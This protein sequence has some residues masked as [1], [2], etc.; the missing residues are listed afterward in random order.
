MRT[1]VTGSSGHLGEALVRTLRVRGDDVIGLDI[2][3]SEWTD[4]VGSVA[5]LDVARGVMAGVDVVIHTATLHKPQLAFL[6]GKPSSKRMS[7]A[8]WLYWTPPP[9]PVSGHLSCPRRRP[10]SAMR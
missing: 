2:R 7:A 5:D 1:L 4:V 9:T 3:P 10:S 6:P 8:L